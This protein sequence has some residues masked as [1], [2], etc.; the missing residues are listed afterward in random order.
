M[1][2]MAQFWVYFFPHLYQWFIKRIKDQCKPVCG[3][4]I[5][6]YKDKN[7]FGNAFNNYL[8]LTSKRDLNW[9][10]LFNPAYNKLAHEVLFSKKKKVSIESVISL[11]NIQV[12]TTFYQKHLGIFLDEKLTFIH[13]NDNA[14]CK[15]DKGI[16]I[17]KN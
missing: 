5:Y 1:L 11:N 10:M 6:V 9:K 4:H 8:F 7:K 12:E 17:I 2:L 3:W 16:A 15:V 14:L 13:Y